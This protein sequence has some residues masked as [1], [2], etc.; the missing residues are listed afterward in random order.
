METLQEI[1]RRIKGTDDL[2]SVV[3]TMKS[4]AAV[5]I[6]Q[7]EQAMRS[8]DDYRRSIE[9]G[10]RAALRSRPLLPRSS[11]PQQTVVLIFGSDQGMVGRF[12][13]AIIDFAENTMHDNGLAAATRDCWVAGAKA[14]GSAED[15]FG[16]LDRQ[17]ALPA[18]SHQVAPAVDEVLL[19]F[20][21]HCSRKGETRLLILYNKPDSGASY[22][23]CRAALYP[24]DQ[25]W[26]RA[27]GGQSWPGRSLPLHRIPAQRLLPAL[28][29]EYLF[30][31]LFE[32]F[33]ASLAAENAAR[34]AA[35]QQAEKK[36][37]EMGEALTSRYHNLRQTSITEELLDVIAGFEALS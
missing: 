21:E 34:L 28:I 8:L 11:S 12:N 23:Q 13:E 35:M 37:E 22:R 9:L 32:A 33:A 27:I 24:P 7:Y 18:S 30:I 5:N 31:S 25:E 36:I 19:R 3:R 17:F 26:L 4:L 14:A 29:R 1:K 10:L 6:R 20:D 15:R 16:P 2:H